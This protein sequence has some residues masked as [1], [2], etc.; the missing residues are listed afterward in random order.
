MFHICFCQAEAVVSLFESGWCR[1]TWPIPVR[2]RPGRVIMEMYII[3]I[4]NLKPHIQKTFPVKINIILPFSFFEGANV[5]QKNEFDG[6][7]VVGG[8]GTHADTALLAEICHEM[9]V[10]LLSVLIILCS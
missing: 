9:Q 4:R 5:L 10:Q 3:L 8:V 1:S 7:V 2:P 6:L